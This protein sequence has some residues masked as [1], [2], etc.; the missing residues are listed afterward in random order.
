M[1]TQGKLKHTTRTA[2]GKVKEIVGR[3]VGNRRM[4][5]RGKTEQLT[6]RIKHTTGKG[7]ATLRH[8][9]RAAKGRTQEIIGSASGNNHM[10][11]RGKLSKA[12]ARISEKFNK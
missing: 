11:M 4:T 9:G 6:A 3:A 8:R 5:S 2:S 10:T 1:T 12:S 7:M